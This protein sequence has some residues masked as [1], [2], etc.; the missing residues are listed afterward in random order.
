MSTNFELHLIFFLIFQ[1]L[2]V[3]QKYNM[4]KEQIYTITCD[5][6]ANMVKLT[7]IMNDQC[8]E[9]NVIETNVN[10]NDSDSDIELEYENGEGTSL[11][12][13]DIENELFNDDFENNGNF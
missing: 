8:E 12:T 6:A 3:L 10:E 9:L 2:E 13:D 5:N 1:L 7:R 11:S 4:V